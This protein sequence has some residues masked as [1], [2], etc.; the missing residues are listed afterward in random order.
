MKVAIIC[1]IDFAGEV[2]QI[3]QLLESKGHILSV[4]YSIEKILQGQM[5]LRQV[6]HM[7]KTGT[8]SDY[9]KSKDLIRWNW[10]RMKGSDAVLV[11]NLDKNGIK[12]YN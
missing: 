11:V 3:K 1:S 4:P 9:A 5:T 2:D 8:F 12:N 7:R 10:D 6:A